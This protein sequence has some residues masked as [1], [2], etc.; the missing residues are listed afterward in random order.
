MN[1]YYLFNNIEKNE[2]LFKDK[3]KVQIKYF[4]I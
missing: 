1:I 3:I 2:N 4:I